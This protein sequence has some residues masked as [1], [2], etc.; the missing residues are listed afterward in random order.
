MTLKKWFIILVAGA[1]TREEIFANFEQDKKV[2]IISANYGRTCAIV[3]LKLRFQHHIFV[4][5]LFDKLTHH[6]VSLSLRQYQFD[7]LQNYDKQH[8]TNVQCA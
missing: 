5:K 4:N 2:I 1:G 8:I 3:L 7:L 6:V